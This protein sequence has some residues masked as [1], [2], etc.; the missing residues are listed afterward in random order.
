[1]PVRSDHDHT[2]RRRFSRRTLLGA[3]LLAGVLVVA[4]TVTALAAGGHSP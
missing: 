4:A 1:M 2:R 3:V